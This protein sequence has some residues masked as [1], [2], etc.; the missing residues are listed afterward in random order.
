MGIAPLEAS[1]VAAIEMAEARAWADCYAA[2]PA[3]FAEAAGLGFDWLGPDVLA[4]RWL[5]SGRRYFSRVIGLGV[6]E[7]ATPELLDQIVAHYD[8]LGIGAYLVQSMAACK[9]ASY[10]A[11]LDARGLQP[12]DAQDRV[13][14]GPAPLEADGLAK[15]HRH[16]VEPVSTTTA[17]NGPSSS[18]ASTA[19]TA[20]TGSNAPDAAICAAIVRAGLNLG[21]HC[22]LA[23]IETPS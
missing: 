18:S 13:V 12:F 3:A 17:V 7:P 19:S 9:P 11:W 1:A 10:E 23:D 4:L 16:A 15:Q 21:V 5:A 14:R 20:A 2:A 6:G 22:F 8:H